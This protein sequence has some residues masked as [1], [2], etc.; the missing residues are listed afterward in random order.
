MSPRQKSLLKQKFNIRIKEIDL[1]LLGELYYKITHNYTGF[2][3]LNI[4]KIY[5]NT[6]YSTSLF[7]VKTFEDFVD[8]FT[9]HNYRII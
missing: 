2:N 8:V 7:N 6:Q 3:I 5:F 4:N 9:M 1:E